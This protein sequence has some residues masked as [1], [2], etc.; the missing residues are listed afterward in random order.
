VDAV[1]GDETAARLR[2]SAVLLAY[3]RPAAVAE[4]LDRLR[5]LP[6][7]EILV[8]DN[9]AD[10]ETADVVRSRP[11]ARLVKPGG[12]TGIAGR[13]LGARE[14]TGGL[15]LFLDDDSYPLAG[16]VESLAAMFDRQADLGAVGGLVRDVDSDGRV[17]LETELGTF[18]W[19]L[20]DG[21]TGPAPPEGL[22]AFFFPEGASLVR[23]EAFLEVG[24]FYEPFFF[25]ST[26]VELSTRLLAAGW[27]VRYQPAAQF[28]HMKVPAGRASLH[29]VLRLRIRNQVWYFWLRFP[30][31][32][33]VLRIAGY[34]FF[35]LL[36]AIYRREPG[37]WLGGMGDAWR[38]RHLVV[39]DRA[40]VPIALL[41]R[42]E[43]GRSRLH[44]QVVLRRL[45]LGA[46]RMIR[47]LTRGP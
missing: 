40:P 9:S 12:N 1:S 35:D 8:V 31:R 15:L 25:G 27:D 10:E 33:A 37:S 16:A 19:W 2:V 29:D 18:D 36:N 46:A 5:T 34:G 38:Q 3:H 44:V 39:A 42:I 28:D 30:T 6:V 24:G 41:A 13:N 4:V 21:A 11:H 45:R 32:Q 17:V 23:R 47:G 7:D 14:A 43:G 22:P 26:E 20:R